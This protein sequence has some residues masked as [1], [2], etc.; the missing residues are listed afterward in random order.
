MAMKPIT[1]LVVT[2]VGAVIGAFV[3]T[4]VGAWREQHAQLDRYQFGKRLGRLLEKANP[5][6][7]IHSMD[8]HPADNDWDF[9]GRT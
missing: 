3:A 4:V 9:E 8:T 1:W 2:I 6:G 7:G 5:L